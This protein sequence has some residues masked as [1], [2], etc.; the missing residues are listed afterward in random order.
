MLSSAETQRRQYKRMHRRGQAALQVDYDTRVRRATRI[1]NFELS[2]IP[3]L[4]QTADYARYRALDAVENY[5]FDPE[6]VDE[7]VAARMLRQQVLGDTTKTFEFIITEAPWRGVL[8]CPPAVML[9]QVDRLQGVLGIPNITLA[10]IPADRQV[11]YLPMHG[12]LLMD[13]EVDIEL[14]V[15]IDELPKH[16]AADWDAVADKLRAEAV[17]GDEA[18]HLLIRASD[19]LRTLNS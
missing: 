8:A 2:V 9:A 14:H 4:L 10:I 6:R 3:G 16:E 5:G 11:P 7:T 13:D 18:R 12:F 15:S 17:T 19:H 1:R